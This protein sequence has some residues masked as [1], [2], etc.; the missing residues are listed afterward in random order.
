MIRGRKRMRVKI[1]KRDGG[2]RKK[3]IIWKSIQD[4]MEKIKVKSL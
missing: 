3:R 4:N 2:R 1:R